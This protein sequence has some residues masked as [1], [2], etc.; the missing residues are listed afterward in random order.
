[1]LKNRT[2]RF[3]E[4]GL[5]LDAWQKL[6]Y[7]DQQDYIRK[8]LSAIKWLSEGYSRTQVCQRV[9]CSYNT[10]ISWMDKYC[11]GGLDEL[12]KP[13]QHRNA[14]QRLSPEQRQELKR[15]LLEDSPRDYGVSRHI[16]T[17]ESLM[18]VMQQR[19]DVSLKSSRVYEILSELGLS[20]QKAHRDYANADPEA[21]K[22]FVEILK[23]TR[24]EGG[25]G[26]DSLF[27]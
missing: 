8:R 27:R 16:W 3:H 21:Q 10:L 15:M 13:I 25:E 1:M 12:V 26:K 4:L 11:S 23:Q 17:A 22:Q 14:P 24:R 7:K 2:G 18:V 20:S 9:G 19:W 5:D 6:Y